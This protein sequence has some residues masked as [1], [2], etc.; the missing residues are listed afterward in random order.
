[1]SIAIIGAG[2]AGLMASVRAAECGASRVLLFEKTISPGRKLLMTGNGRC[3]VSNAADIKSYPE[4]YFGNGKFLYKALHA[5]SPSDLHVFFE[6][7]GVHLKEEAGGRLFPVSDQAE[8]ILR[9][10]IT[11]AKELGVEFHTEEPVTGIR[12]GRN[13]KVSGITTARNS[14]DVDACILTTGGSSWPGTG[15]TGDGYRIAARLGHEIIPIRAGLAPVDSAEAAAQV[16]QGVALRN[17]GLRAYSGADELAHSKGDI[18]FSHTGLTGP[19]VFRVSRSLPAE[20]EKYGDGKIRVAVDLLP[21]QTGEAL[22]ESMAGLLA[23]NQNR[24]L[25]HVLK[26]FGPESYMACLMTNAGIEN[27][28]FCRD[29]RK[30]SREKLLSLI[31]S[32]PLTVKKPPSMAAAMVTAGGVSLKEV[33]PKT[34]ES[35]IVP[36]LFLA[37]EVLDIDGD[38]GGFNLQA[39]FSTGFTA[40]TSAAQHIGPT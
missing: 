10:L 34:M 19:A 13:G 18:L 31:K 33:D 36:G 8:D 3:N 21:H 35:K 23:R 27:Q 20:P 15:S 40:G 12:T 38:T 22:R 14:Y 26:E 28:I 2:P 29:L 7:R 32:F 37:G 6:A 11:R 16:L 25:L 17:T 4:N 39:A 1:M 5:F 9:V 24:K 30:E